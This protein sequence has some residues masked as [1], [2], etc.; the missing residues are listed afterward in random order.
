MFSVTAGVLFVGEEQGFSDGHV[1]A[2]ICWI[3]SAAG[4]FRYAITVPRA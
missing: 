4:A 1:V 2:A 3:A